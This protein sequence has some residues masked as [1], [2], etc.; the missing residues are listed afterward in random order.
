MNLRWQAA[1]C[2]LVSGLRWTHWTDVVRHVDPYLVW[3]DVTGFASLW[4]R[5]EG[6]SWSDSSLPL[7]VELDESASLWLT[8]GREA[9]P[10]RRDC[11]VTLAHLDI[12]A[13]YKQV[14]DDGAQELQH[15]FF[16]ARCSPSAL[17][18]LMVDPCVKRIQLGLP[19]IP[20]ADTA[21]PVYEGKPVDGSPQPRTIVAFIDDGC[22]FAHSRFIGPAGATRVQ[23]LWDQD[24]RRSPVGPWKPVDE[25]GYGAELGPAELAAASRLDGPIAP[26]ASLDYV[27]V[28]LDR[29]RHSTSIATQSPSRPPAM[30]MLSSSHGAGV[31]DLAVGWPQAPQ[32]TQVEP[33]AEHHGFQWPPQLSDVDT[34]ASCPL[35]FVQLPTQTVLDTSGG[36][37]GVHV[38]DAI[39]Y[40]IERA[41]R[42]PYLNDNRTGPLDVRRKD[43]QLIVN[44]SF[45]AIGGS[46]DGTSILEQAME[47]MVN[48]RDDVPLWLVLAAGNAHRSRT[49]SRIDLGPQQCKQFH[50]RVAPD[51]PHE[52]YLEIWLPDAER[53]AARSLPEQVVK[54]FQ[55]RVVPPDGDPLPLADYGDVKVFVDESDPQGRPLA[56]IVFARRVSQGLRGTMV[57]LAVAPTRLPLAGEQQ[58]HAAGLHGW[59][60]VEVAYA[61]AGAVTAPVVRVHAWTERNDLIYGN[62]RPQQAQL[63][64]DEP[65]PEPT[66]FTGESLAAIAQCTAPW[67]TSEY[68]PR[69]L[70]ADA[71]LASLAGADPV[72]ADYEAARLGRGVVVVAG[73]YRLAD[74]EM[75]TDS[76]GGPSRLLGDADERGELWRALSADREACAA[77]RTRVAAGSLRLAPDVDAP[78]DAGPAMPGL[79]VCGMRDGQRSRLGGTSGAA[80]GATRHLADTA[81]GNRV[82]KGPRPAPSLGDGPDPAPRAVRDARPSPTPALDDAFRRGRRR[83]R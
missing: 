68:M 28:R 65:V 12:P 69:P 33:A 8:P 58:A 59:W 15:R 56:G 75:S 76:S 80:A 60:R 39:H 17:S 54:D 32:R 7:L 14:W 51:H 3:A 13:S 43:N 19:R 71:A 83:L 37:L 4:H 36:S 34:S 42:I 26:Y 53:D 52:S 16:T 31:M 35:I 23:Y 18:A 5:A 77:Y 6:E 20:R 30:A 63:W 40:V 64:S 29:D 46:H 11:S 82:K 79:R 24:D 1:P 73:A 70:Q 49:H 61:P 9:D 41:R 47:A 74:G 21:P 22:A 2:G 50:W 66:E 55:L 44:V 10:A 25:L 57:L 81:F 67:V 45:G 78:G 48:D 38:L 72:R 27:P 62:L